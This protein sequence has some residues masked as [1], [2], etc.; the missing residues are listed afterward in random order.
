MFP[1]HENPPAVL[2]SALRPPAQEGHGGVG[3][4]SVEATRLI[5][6]PV[7]SDLV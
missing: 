7:L 6:G 5:M 1:S 3:V 2:H 4:S